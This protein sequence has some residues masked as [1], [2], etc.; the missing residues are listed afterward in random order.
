MLTLLVPDKHEKHIVKVFLI[1]GLEEGEIILF[2]VQ[3]ISYP[4]LDINPD[5]LSKYEKHFVKEFFCSEAW[6]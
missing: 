2:P 5:L 1:K 6:K 4:V 3:I